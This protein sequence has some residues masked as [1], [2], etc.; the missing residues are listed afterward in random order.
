[1]STFSVM[2]DMNDHKCQVLTQK[3]HHSKLDIL[4]VCVET[5]AKSLT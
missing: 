1:M 3:T 2:L 5:K 4:L